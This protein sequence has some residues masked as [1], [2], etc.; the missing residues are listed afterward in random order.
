MVKTDKEE[1]TPK[2]VG[3]FSN[4]KNKIKTRASKKEAS[5]TSEKVVELVPATVVESTEP[6]TPPET[7]TAPDGTEYTLKANDPIPAGDN[8]IEYNGINYIARD[9]MKASMDALREEVETIQGRHDKA[10]ETVGVLR[11]KQAPK[12]KT[13]NDFLT[14]E[15]KVTELNAE[16]GI[17]V[18]ERDRYKT[19]AD[20]VMQTYENKETTY[21]QTKQENEK[22][23]KENAKLGKLCEEFPITIN[24]QERHI[25]VLTKAREA[26]KKEL[27]ERIERSTEVDLAFIEY[28]RQ[29]A[30]ELSVAQDEAANYKK[31]LRYKVEELATEVEKCGEFENKYLAEKDRADGLSDKIKGLPTPLTQMVPLHTVQKPKK[32]T[33]GPAQPPVKGPAQ[34]PAISVVTLIPETINGYLDALGPKYDPS[35]D[36]EILARHE[37]LEE[38]GLIGGSELIHFIRAADMDPVIGLAACNKY[39]ALK[40][41]SGNAN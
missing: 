12:G 23:T 15:N 2:R 32:S 33:K 29:S 18:I 39:H 31:Q 28:K 34:P 3:F 10:A 6:V 21:T 5:K 37:Q 19:A 16:K 38:K 7:Y 24:K 36:K 35:K 1:S 13:V 40:E 25:A 27:A 9:Y 41:A 20:G 11:T 26:D 14:L 22:L 4:L 30:E 17:L 8:G